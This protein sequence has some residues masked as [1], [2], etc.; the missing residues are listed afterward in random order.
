M[1]AATVHRK[2]GRKAPPPEPVITAAPAAKPQA[3]TPG[4]P[5]VPVWDGAP[6]TVG[7]LV[8]GTPR[9]GSPLLRNSGERDIEPRRKH[10]I[11]KERDPTGARVALHGLDQERAQAALEAFVLRAWDE[12]YRAVP[13]LAAQGVRG[14]GVEPQGATGWVAARALSGGVSAT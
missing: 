10:R 8:K 7:E 3:K 13:V 5:P 12:G 1:V 2:P 6:F 4:P 14:A 9:A 11:A